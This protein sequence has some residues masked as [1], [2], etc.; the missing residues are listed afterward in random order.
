MEIH[1]IVSRDE[2]I[3]ARKHLLARERNSHDCVTSAVSS[4]VICHGCGSTNNTG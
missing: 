2:W 3:E 4:D 1:K